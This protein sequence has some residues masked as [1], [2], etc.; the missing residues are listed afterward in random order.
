[1]PACRCVEAVILR[2]VCIW[3]QGVA[4]VIPAEQEH[5]YE[6]LV[7]AEVLTGDGRVDHADREQLRSQPAQ[8]HGS[9]CSAPQERA[10]RDE[11]VQRIVHNQ[12]PNDQTLSADYFNARN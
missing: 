4:I 2:T 10:S 1:M 12:I 11:I 3:Y 7:I 6:G 8:A 5:A 9:T